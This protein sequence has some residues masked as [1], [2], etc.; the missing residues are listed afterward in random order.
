MTYESMKFTNFNQLR[1]YSNFSESDNDKLLAL[2]SN[3]VKYYKAI[4]I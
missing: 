4:Y 2:K 1:K 3:L